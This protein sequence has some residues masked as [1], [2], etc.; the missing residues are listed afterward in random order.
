MHFID[1][2]SFPGDYTG[3]I[4]LNVSVPVEYWIFNRNLGL[5]LLAYSNYT[6]MSGNYRDAL[7][8]RLSG[9]QIPKS[10]SAD[11]DVAPFLTLHANWT[12]YRS[13]LPSPILTYS[14]PSLSATR[15][16]RAASKEILQKSK[17]EP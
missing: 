10:G 7:G 6:K 11:H 8:Y 1:A 13:L 14:D 15:I 4:Q 17:S 3:W 9:I 12:N 16:K 2:V 5:L